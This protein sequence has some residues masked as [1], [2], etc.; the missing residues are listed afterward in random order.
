M[1]CLITILARGGSAGVPSKNIKSLNGKP[2]IYYTI[3]VAQKLQT[4]LDAHIGLSTDSVEIRKVASDCGLSTD[5]LRPSEFATS[6]VSKKGALS[7]LLHHME[8][9]NSCSYDFV[10]DL[11]VTSPLRKPE[12]IIEGLGI[13]HNDEQA[14]NLITVS[15]PSRNPYFNMVERKE[16]GYFDV[17]KKPENPFYSR[18]DAPEVFSM[19]SNF[20]IFRR[21]YFDSQFAG[22]FTDSTLVHLIKYPCFDIDDP[23]DFEFMEFLFQKGQFETLQKQTN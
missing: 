8:K 7:H 20:Y 22:T 14:L 21:R 23:L 11:D 13:I 17:V 3:Q 12:S 10:V 18:Q 16:H 5:Y 2:M 15:R 1:K 19:N 9:K 6:T 4:L